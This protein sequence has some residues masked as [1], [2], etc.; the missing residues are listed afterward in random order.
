MIISPPKARIG[1]AM[2]LSDFFRSAREFFDGIKE[3]F[4]ERTVDAVEAELKD[5]E[6]AFGLLLFG[7]VMGMPV[8]SSFVGISLLPYVERE[9]IIMLSTSRLLDDFASHWFEIADI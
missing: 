4:K 8:F 3:G 1:R 2:R 7:S 6:G 5:M 9:V